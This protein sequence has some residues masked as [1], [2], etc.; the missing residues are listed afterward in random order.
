MLTLQK[1]ALRIKNLHLLAHF[2]PLASK[3][4][5]LLFNEF[6]CYPVGI[7]KYKAYHKMLNQFITSL[8]SHTSNVHSPNTRSTIKC[9]FVPRVESSFLQRQLPYAGYIFWNKLPFNIRSQLC[10]QTFKFELKI[11]YF[12]HNYD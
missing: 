5:T 1:K 8:F 10:K 6:Y 2:K 9:F 4:R 11:T 3:L 7:F 12:F